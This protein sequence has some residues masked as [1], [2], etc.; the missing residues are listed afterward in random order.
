MV[1]LISRLVTHEINATLLALISE[2]EVK[3]A[4]FEL[5]NTKAP[6]PNCF[7]SLFYQNN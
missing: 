4:V 7:S 6:S 5:G 3:E 1:R 2:D